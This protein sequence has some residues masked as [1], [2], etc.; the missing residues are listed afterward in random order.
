V[1]EQDE[2]FMKK[3]QATLNE[4]IGGNGNQ[5]FKVAPKKFGVF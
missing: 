1:R 2:Q 4:K 5:T 3:Q